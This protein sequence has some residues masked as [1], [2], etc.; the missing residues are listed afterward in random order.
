M[1]TQSIL[2]IAGSIV[3]Y[4][5]LQ[6]FILR[7]LVFFDV[8][9]CFVYLSVIIF[10]PSNTPTSTALIIAF[11]TGLAVDMFYNTAGLHASALLLVAFVRGFVLKVLFPSRGLE[12]EI[13]IS[14]EGMGIERFVR[15]IVVMTFIHNL[16]L[17]FLEAGSFNF[18]LNTSLKVI[19][20]LVFS[21]I[22]TFLIHVNLKS[23][24]N[25]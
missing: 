5:I 24:Q 13:V 12:N 20:T 4:L 23:L 17:F 21:S 7:N 18:F 25:S 10:L 11:L 14:V 15:Y 22:V 16:Y 8:A 3:I 9:F 19:A 6:V 1:N 2:K